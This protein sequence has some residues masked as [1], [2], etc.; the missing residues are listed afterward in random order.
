VRATL[1]VMTL[2]AGA[3][4]AHADPVEVISPQADGVSVTIYRD[5]FA[6]I[7]ET[8]TVD[9]PEGPVTLS[10]DGVVETLL[11]ESAVVTDLGRA[12]EERNFDYDELSP[13]KL[14]S[15]S[16][17]KSVTITRTMPGAGRVVQS[18]ATIVAANSGGI[19]L[20]T[21]Q[22]NE[23]L[24]CSGLPERLTFDE[25]PADLHARPRLSIRLV[26][27]KA[28]KRTIRLSYLAHGFAWK[29]DYVA[30]L[31]PAGTRMDLTGWVTLQNYTQASFR[32]A[33]VQVVAG[34]LHLV[35]KDDGGTSLTG[36]SDSYSDESQ[37]TEARED[38]LQELQQQLAPK[39]S[40]LQLFAGC[41]A[42]PEP[43]APDQSHAESVERFD[44]VVVTGMRG[45]LRMSMAV[46]RESMS[47]ERESLGD[48]QL[49]RLPWATDLNARQT[50]Q[51]VFLVKPRVK[52]DRY[53]SYVFAAQNNRDPE[54]FEPMTPE[55]IVSFEN[56]KASGLGEPLP[57]G[58]MR[59]FD[60]TDGG[61]LFAGE[62]RMSDKPVNVPVE[63][64][65]AQ[66][67]NLGLT[68]DVRRPAPEELRDA[69]LAE[70]VDVELRAFNAKSVPVTLEIRQYADDYMSGAT[71][72]K[73][74][75]RFRRKY[76]D[77]A[78][79]LRVP[80]N[81]TR[82]LTYRLEIPNAPDQ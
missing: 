64:E 38:A 26:A 14:L 17:G 61:E 45:S 55:S 7:T 4:A 21:E 42:L 56:R 52:I 63:L 20:R 30:R 65:L 75:A 15:K 73:S 9:L 47:V 16:I 67:L 5:L 11:P 12:L 28:G 71:I 70:R 48:Y 80:A 43:N 35:D 39:D 51:A 54:N 13:D 79:R 59:M 1:L 69:E 77:F 78:W 82:T 19:T 23:A 74:S 37:L 57:A 36:N 41:H 62:V 27:G 32:G 2:L 3:H 50:K 29:S 33:Q 25:L 72:P 81:G 22:G 34:K 49:Y 58:M 40:S 60:T 68:L 53:Y 6:L 76:G 31:N 24:H 8:R 44:M 10:F 66:A 46:K 18:R